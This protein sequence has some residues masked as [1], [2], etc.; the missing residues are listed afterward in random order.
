MDGD[1]A[2]W[3]SAMAPVTIVV[4]TDL[5]CPFCAQNHAT[6]VAMKRRYGE[7]RLRVVVKHLP[8]AM[9]PQAPAA[10]RVTQAVLASAGPQKAFAFLDLAYARPDAVS[11]GRFPELVREVGLDPESVLAHAEDSATADA[12]LADVELAQRLGVTGV[13][14]LRVNGRP[15]TGV[16]TED[17]LRAAIDEELRATA[18]LARNGVRSSEIYA[19]RVAANLARPTA[20]HVP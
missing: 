10:A 14:H 12:V 7:E 16:Q 15:F 3:G 18:E 1:D 20:L 11:S 17:T 19:L 2:V 5:E 6:L 13:P 8:L 9:H 4:F